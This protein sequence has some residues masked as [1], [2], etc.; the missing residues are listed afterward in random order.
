MTEPIDP[1]KIEN[2][3]A[4]LEPEPPKFCPHEPFLKQKVFLRSNALEIL[5]G[6]RASGGKSDALL[7]SASQ[8]VDV[9][10]YAAMLFRN[11][12][13]DL[14]LPGALLDR[15]IEWWAGI[16]DVQWNSQTHTFKFPSGA[17]ITFG[18]LDRPTDHL[19]YKGSELQFIGYDEVTEIREEHYTYMFSRLR[20]PSGKGN[21][22][23]NK[24]PLRVR[25]TSN[26]APNWVRRRFIESND[27]NRLYIPSG[28]SDNPFIDR[29]AYMASL[30]RVGA[31]E[32]ARLRDGDWYADEEGTKFSKGDF[33]IASPE[34]IPEEV[35]MN[36]VR[37]WD[38][39]ATE[40]TTRNPDPD[41]TAGALV[42]VVNGIMYILDMKHERF[43]P[44]GVERLVRQTA[45]QDGPLVK[46][47]ME[48]EGGASG[49]I[50]IDHYARHILL[51]YDFDGHPAIKDK[52]ARAD[53][54]AGKVKRGEVVLM[55]GH[56]NHEFLDEASGFGVA[57]V[58]DDQVDAVSGAFEVLTGLGGKAKRPIEIIV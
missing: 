20:K 17:T 24:V 36:Q 28:V 50:T 16:P 42:A 54:W 41:W 22:A 37:Y 21:M 14:T 9:P 8:Y 7:M 45:D 47:R 5:F 30:E 18:Y 46:V 19:R 43:N 48:K 27:P 58:H 6:G 39:A 25:A 1:S 40:P 13:S 23:L 2:L 34:E 35:F 11:T 12:Y 38:L 53:L 52:E 57:G 51:G 32:R 3:L 44:D 49:K 15:A 33:K 31:V 4:F 10:G 56:W 26:P 55:R 29:E